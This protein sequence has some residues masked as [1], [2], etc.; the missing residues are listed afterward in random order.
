MRSQDLTTSEIRGLL[1]R[2][3]IDLSFDEIA[4]V[5]ARRLTMSEASKKALADPEVRKRMSEASKKALRHCAICGKVG[6]YAK[7][8]REVNTA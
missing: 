3:N 2:E 5:K 1:R 6:H 4:D 8:C 7:T